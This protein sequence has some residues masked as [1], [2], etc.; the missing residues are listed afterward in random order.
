MVKGNDPM[1]KRD[2]R[3]LEA[4]AYPTLQPDQTRPHVLK[5]R[6]RKATKA[7]VWHGQDQ[8]LPL[9]PFVRTVERG[10]LWARLAGALSGVGETANQIMGVDAELTKATAAREDAAARRAAAEETMPARP[11]AGSQPAPELPAPAEPPA[12]K[13]YIGTVMEWIGLLAIG[14]IDVPFNYVAAQ[15]M[16][17]PASGRLPFALGWALANVVIAL[18]VGRIFAEYDRQRDVPHYKLLVM[19]A[20]L[21][22]VVV[23]AV[24]IAEMREAYQRA[25]YAVMRT[26]Q[27]SFAVGENWLPW[28]VVFSVAVVIC[29]AAIAYAAAPEDRGA[30]WRWCK[31]LMR[32][33]VAG[34]L[35]RRQHLAQQA[36]W[37]K[38]QAE[39][40]KLRQE[41][42]A[43]AGREA[44]LAAELGR[45]ASG[46]GMAEAQIR[47]VCEIQ[48][49]VGEAAQHNLNQHLAEGR[50]LR[51]H[52]LLQRFKDFFGG[53]DADALEPLPQVSPMATLEVWRVAVAQ[54]D[55]ATCVAKGK[56]KERGYKV[57]DGSTLT[58]VE[59]EVERLSAEIKRMD[60]G[61]PR[62]NGNGSHR[63]GTTRPR[64]GDA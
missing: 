1:P 31:A 12:H 10:G 64:K 8:P 53:R 52:G 25:I 32:W 47:T 18:I 54:A 27:A 42:A 20:A 37:A 40:A 33:L 61:S 26:E 51:R 17:M 28:L 60:K 36:E 39:V 15:V 55:Q 6:A 29:G 59:A 45:L 2:R 58:Q 49:S 23:G 9:L 46:L 13:R 21:I 44:E 56:L 16:A 62:S 57:T 14:A 41:E 63:R 22:S 43:A 38:D 50:Y 5:F 24:A 35:R 34:H 30:A 11:R 19:A 3:E 7:R 48:A 4:S